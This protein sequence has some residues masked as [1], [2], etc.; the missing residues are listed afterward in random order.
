MNRIVVISSDAMVGEDLEIYRGM[1]SY[2]KYFEGGAEIRKV[3]S[4]YPTVTFP[5]H[6]T[7]MTGFYPDK[8]GIFSNMQ[9][10]PGS[11]PTPWQWNNSFLKCTDIF[12]E[13]KKKGISTSAVL[14]PVTAFNDA[15]DYHIADYWAQSDEE[16]TVEAFRR[17][18]SDESVVRI[19]ERNMHFFEGRERVH[20]YRDEFGMAS[21]ADIIREYAPQLLMVHPA[22][23]DDARHRYGVFGPHIEDALRDLDRWIS[24]IGEALEERGILEETDIFLVSDHGQM[25]VSRNIALNV[26]FKEEGLITVN[27]DGSLRD[28]KA[29]CLSNGMSAIVFLKDKDDRSLYNQVKT[30]L[31]RLLKEEVYGFSR[32]F[33]EEEARELHHYGGPFFFV[34][35][36]DGYT[37]FSDSFSRPL[38]KPL[39]NYDYRFGHATHGYLPHK[40][41]QPMLVAK[42][43]HIR[44]GAIVE[45][46][47][48]VNEAPTYAKILGFS[49]PGADGKA[50]DEILLY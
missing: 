44:S 17:S 18:G 22:N 5:A 28:W 32:I 37:G 6:A 24:M 20:P 49:I 12:R 48:I 26:I 33:E 36:T 23:I 13:A 1:P 14:W 16:T 50:I 38:V 34:L 27:R 43:P 3:S 2:K 40:G 25:D 41:P 30:L 47:H 11:D 35:E 7:M 42:G 39:D 21:A 15:I 29:W 31:D 4:I 10:I 46:S 19:I 9:L 8:T 45:S